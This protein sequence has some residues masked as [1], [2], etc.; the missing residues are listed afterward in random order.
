M[1]R[2]AW[3][4]AAAVWVVGLAC[5][6]ALYFALDAFFGVGLLGLLMGFLAFSLAGDLLLALQNERATER[7][8][9]VEHND[10]VG[11]RGV[12]LES[13]RAGASGFEGRVRL[14]GE[15]WHARSASP[16]VDEGEAVIVVGRERLTLL[17]EPVAQHVEE[18]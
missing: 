18:T 14:G 7:G 9:T 4:R 1:N 12:A 3:A 11:R 10:I 5:A 13:F 15:R 17:V 8:H 16:G 2:P 6:L